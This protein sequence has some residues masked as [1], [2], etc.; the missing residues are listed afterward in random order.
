MTTIQTAKRKSKGNGMTF[1]EALSEQERIQRDIDIGGCARAFGVKGI[2]YEKY[3]WL[4]NNNML[5]G[6]FNEC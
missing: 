5:G 4:N 2:S 6:E 3:E 1:A